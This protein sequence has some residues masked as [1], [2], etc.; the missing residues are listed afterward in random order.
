MDRRSFVLG[1]QAAYRDL[2]IVAATLVGLSR[3]VETPLVWLVA[4][5]LLAAMLSGAQVLADE[6]SPAEAVAA[7]R[8]KP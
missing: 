3:L 7:S 2:A 8:S 4:A 5:L 6:A 1:D